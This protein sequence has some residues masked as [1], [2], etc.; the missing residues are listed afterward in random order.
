V[1]AL[2]ERAVGVKPCYV[3]KPNPL[4]IRSVLNAF[5]AN[6]EYRAMIGDRINTDIVAGLER[7]SRR[8]T[9]SAG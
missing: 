4:M 1:A 8:S 7:G 6:S 3:G 5:E 2:V 9:C